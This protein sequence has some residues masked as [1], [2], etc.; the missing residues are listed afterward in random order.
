MS[1]PSAISLATL[2]AFSHLDVKLPDGSHLNI[3]DVL[4]AQAIPEPVPFVDMARHLRCA[5]P[6]DRHVLAFKLQLVEEYLVALLVLVDKPLGKSLGQLLRISL[7]TSMLNRRSFF[8]SAS[9]SLKPILRTRVFFTLPPQHPVS[10]ARHV[11]DLLAHALTSIYFFMDQRPAFPGP[12]ASLWCFLGSNM[13]AARRRRPSPDG[14]SFPGRF[15]QGC[16]CQRCSL[17]CRSRSRELINHFSGRITVAED[18]L[19][20]SF[21]S[22]LALE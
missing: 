6:I 7:S 17:C 14:A 21:T 5:G 15:L 11:V 8:T 16:R 9:T 10:L 12:G 3:N 22:P 2:S 4:E 18:H 13:G 20:L 1:S 19:V